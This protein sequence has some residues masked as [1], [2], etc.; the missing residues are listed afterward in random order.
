MRKYMFI[1][2]IFIMVCT[3]CSREQSSMNNDN[4][5]KVI[6]T[7]NNHHQSA[8]DTLNQ[9]DYKKLKS[10]DQKKNE[11]KLN[12]SD[13]NILVQ[14]VHTEEEAMD[15]VYLI[16]KQHEEIIFAKKLGAITKFD[17]EYDIM[18]YWLEEPT[19]F[20]KDQLDDIVVHRHYGS[21]LFFRQNKNN[22]TNVHVMPIVLD[23][24]I[25][26]DSLILEDRLTGL[27]D[28][29]K[30]SYYL[31]DQFKVN[32]IL[33]HKSTKDQETFKLHMPDLI[34]RNSV[35]TLKDKTYIV[36]EKIFTAKGTDYIISQLLEYNKISKHL[37]LV[38]L[39]LD[40]YKEN[41]KK[42]KVSRELFDREK[43]ANIFGN[44][45]KVKKF[46]GVWSTSE[47]KDEQN[48]ELLLI[49]ED[50][51]S[52]GLNMAVHRIEGEI[53]DVDYDE[54]T[55]NVETLF[56]PA[57]DLQGGTPYSS[58]FKLNIYK[59]NGKPVLVDSRGLTYFKLMDSV[60]E[61]K[62]LEMNEK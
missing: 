10:F 28:D 2:L 37:E 51:I 44:D 60:K 33:K 24:K 54:H 5:K 43:T 30:L 11:I 49:T 17:R 34:Q 22:F 8:I 23:A 61:F 3:A 47:N 40:P 56:T 1:L 21:S 35:K 16:A 62:S 29:L 41:E 15:N 46:Y 25:Q 18:P 59:I 31:I 4:E 57:S 14:L 39:S 42:F 50:T 19:D 45:G 9:M 53:Q 20:T 32:S 7:E 58:T 38:G 27:S 6:K 52:N 12:P 36:D 55:L 13:N 48:S 26:N